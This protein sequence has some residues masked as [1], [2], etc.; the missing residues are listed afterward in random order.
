MSR[1]WLALLLLI[2]LTGMLS[3]CWDNR[4]PRRRAYVLGLAIDP[5]PKGGSDISVSVQLPIPGQSRPTGSGGG[6][7]GGGQGQPEF[8]L[9][10]GS[11]PTLLKA[12]EGAQ[13]LISRELFLGQMRAVVLSSTL[14]AAQMNH[15]M[16]SLWTQPE[17][18]ETIYLVQARGRASDLL[19]QPV[20][21]ERLPALYFN[22]IF[23]AVRRM[24]VSEPVQ[25]WQYWRALRT[26]GWDPVLPTV[27]I[28]GE[29]FL[30][31]RGLALFRE[32]EPAGTL[33]GDEAQG[34]LWI[35]GR[36]RGGVVSA[37]TS[38]GPISA[39][40]LQ[41]SRTVS[42]RFQ[43]GKPIFRVAMRVIG[44]AG[45]TARRHT[46]T[47]DLKEIENRIGAVI[48]GQVRSAITKVQA[49]RADP[50]G[51][52]RLL[53]YRYPHYYDQVNWRELFPTVV[54][55]TVVDVNLVRKGTLE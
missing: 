36:A 33:D 30:S 47:S 31:M 51:F 4:E 52:G 15:V 45:L 54:I 9:V 22:N 43:G 55:E 13:Q 1:R 34:Y 19:A 16:T 53:Y 7:G 18:D 10:R 41:V 46:D 38:N 32:N 25:L 20:K 39:R 6:G 8:Y 12:L 37:K 27:A 21:L 11:G 2:A 26:S 40:D 3:G 42:V 5:D 28:A 48:E 14:S 49:S 29:G 23:E 44:S 35:M 24:T 17:I 50:F